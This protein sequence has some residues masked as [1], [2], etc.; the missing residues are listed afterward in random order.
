MNRSKSQHKFNATHLEDTFK[1]GIKGYSKRRWTTRDAMKFHNEIYNYRRDL[2]PTRSVPSE[3]NPGY[4]TLDTNFF[5]IVSRQKTVE[6]DMNTH[7]V[8]EKYG[9]NEGISYGANDLS[10][11]FMFILQ[12]LLMHGI[13]MY[14]MEWGDVRFVRKTYS[15]P[16]Y[17]SYVNTATVSFNR[18]KSEI[19]AK[20]RYSWLTKK[21]NTYYTYNNHNF[22][23]DETF[24]LTHPTHFPSSPLRESMSYIDK[25]REGSNFSLLQGEAFANPENHAMPI[26]RARYDLSEKHW[27]AQYIARLK[28]RRIFKQT[29]GGLGVNLNTFYEAYAF[30]EYK[31]HLNDIRNYLISEFNSQIL[32]R[33]KEKNNITE[34]IVLEYAGFTSNE[35]IDSAL[36]SIKTVF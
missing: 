19:F 33:V 28:V 26:E 10:Q 21:L 13:S 27:H 17:L 1:E 8:I 15:V 32:A 6:R 7:F 23:E 4:S 3:K 2:F 14:C 35:D 22:M 34:D 18:G 30:A 5:R 12:D 24:L 36:R 25:V 16:L 11:F 9:R 29:V 20:Q 31:K